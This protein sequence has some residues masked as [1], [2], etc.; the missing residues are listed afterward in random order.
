MA[1]LDQKGRSDFLG[2]LKDLGGG[3]RLYRTKFP[4]SAALSGRPP[5][6]DPLF[7]AGRLAPTRS[8]P[9]R[10]PALGKGLLGTHG[11]G[12]S[13]V[14][15]APRPA[16]C[17]SQPPAHSRTTPPSP[18][19]APPIQPT[20]R[21]A[22][23]MMCHDT[24]RSIQMASESLLLRERDLPIRWVRGWEEASAAPQPIRSPQRTELQR[25]RGHDRGD[26]QGDCDPARQPA[27]R[28]VRP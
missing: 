16:A 6:P 15:P 27:G 23:V 20:A 11:S 24:V 26:P 17:R 22:Q 25:L 8:H 18:P 9:S 7:N 2:M 13:V 4:P 5:P 1:G 19:L 21:D 3:V 10:T 14:R 12:E 28:P